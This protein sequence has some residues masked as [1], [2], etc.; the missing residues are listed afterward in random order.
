VKIRVVRNFS[1][2]FAPDLTPPEMLRLSVFGL[3]HWA[4]DS[5]TL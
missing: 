5:R 2:L 4:Y 1:P 3:L